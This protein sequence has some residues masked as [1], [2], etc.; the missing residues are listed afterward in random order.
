MA[1]ETVSFEVAQA[2]AVGAVE[3]PVISALEAFALNEIVL[4][5]ADAHLACP[6]LVLG[7]A[8]AMIASQVFALVALTEVG[9]LIE[10][11][12]S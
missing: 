3:V 10:M 7:A 2:D 6:G 1:V 9:E 5:L 4:F 12:I 11:G 8:E